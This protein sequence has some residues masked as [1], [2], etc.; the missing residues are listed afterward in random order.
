MP[1]SEASEPSENYGGQAAGSGG[2]TAVDRSN[3]KIPECKDPNNAE[4][5]MIWKKKIKGLL[6]AY[7]GLTEKRLAPLVFCT[8]EGDLM[9]ACKNLDIENDLHQD[10]GLKTLFAKIDE[11]FDKPAYTKSDETSK[12][13]ETMGRR[14]G[15]TMKT[16]IHDLKDALEMM[17]A[18]DSD[19]KVSN[20]NYAQRL[21]RKSGLAKQERKS[22]LAA[23][24]CANGIPQR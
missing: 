2:V 24:R 21:L 23:A 8:L 5:L 10:T 19:M 13:Y 11:R 22:V 16:Y 18:E 1:D 15:T 12:K 3:P 9:R 20:V 17:Y 7:D 6:F 4:Q 14:Y